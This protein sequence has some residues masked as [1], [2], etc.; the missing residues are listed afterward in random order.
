MKQVWNRLRGVFEASLDILTRMNLLVATWDTPLPADAP[1]Y[2][3]FVSAFE[4][5]L[6]GRTVLVPW[7][8]PAEAQK[9]D[10]RPLNGF[11]RMANQPACVKVGVRDKSVL[12]QL[13]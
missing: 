6:W 5:Y 12:A 3:A 11:V 4:A 8:K 13:D 9:R 2:S 10:S 7:L 1:G